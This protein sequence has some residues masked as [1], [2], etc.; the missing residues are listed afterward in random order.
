MRAKLGVQTDLDFTGKH[1]NLMP[2]TKDICR[3]S[4]SSALTPVQRVSMRTLV[5]YLMRD[6]SN[7]HILETLSEQN[8]N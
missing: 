6:F 8:Q 4:D 5:W 3:L 1:S 7:E 2:Y